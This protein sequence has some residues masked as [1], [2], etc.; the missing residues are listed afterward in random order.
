MSPKRR[1]SGRTGDLARGH[2]HEPAPR[3]RRGKHP[4]RPDPPN[5][6]LAERATEHRSHAASAE[7]R[8]RAHLRRSISVPSSCIRRETAT[9]AVHDT[10]LRVRRGAPRS[11]GLED[12]PASTAQPSISVPL[13]T[14]KQSVLV[15]D[16]PFSPLLVSVG[17]AR[18][19]AQLA[20]FQPLNQ[21]DLTSP[22][23]FT[24]YPTAKQLL[25]L[26]TTRRSE[27]CPSCRRVGLGT[28]AQLCR[29]TFDQR[30]KTEAVV[31]ARVSD[32][33]QLVCWCTTRS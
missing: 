17:W 3:T 4:T 7:Q 30:W 2:A 1:R 28:I 8:E 22:E 14:A 5:N 20:P 18:T 13:P 15:H 23:L 33:K 21:R 12:G 27:D 10:P 26:C 29:S 6:W 11:W 32:A 9:G 19:I 24:E 25:V 16:T 31:A